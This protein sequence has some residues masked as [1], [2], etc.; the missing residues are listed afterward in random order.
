[1][2]CAFPSLTANTTFTY[3]PHR[4]ACI[5]GVVK[6]GARVNGYQAHGAGGLRSVAAW[7]EAGLSPH[8]A[9]QPLPCRLRRGQ[10]QFGR[11]GRLRSIV[12]LVT[13]GRIPPHQLVSSNGGC[14]MSD[15][16]CAQ[17]P[18]IKSPLAALRPSHRNPPAY[19][20]M[21]VVTHQVTIRSGII[22]RGTIGPGPFSGESAVNTPSNA[23]GI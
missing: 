23:H 17:N 12:L 22:D 18:S 20:V 2:T 9:R 14:R 21:M 19:P 3:M 11:L 4:L 8:A 10:S 16:G 13:A 7:R 15:T 1:M 6:G 5:G